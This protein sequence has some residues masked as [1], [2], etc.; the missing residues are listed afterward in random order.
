VRLRD[1]GCDMGQGY[2]IGRPMAEPEV[3]YPEAI[4]L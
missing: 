3:T 2:L 1:W 4:K